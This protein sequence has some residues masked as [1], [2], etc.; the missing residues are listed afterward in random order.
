MTQRRF[1]SVYHCSTL[2]LYLQPCH[3]L[4]LALEPSLFRL[5]FDY[6]DLRSLARLECCCTTLQSM[7]VDTNIYRKKWVDVCERTGQSEGRGA[8]A[9]V[10]TSRYYK[11]KLSEYY[12]RSGGIF[13]GK[14]THWG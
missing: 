11:R 4:T 9:S 7:V 14:H 10:E 6:L 5:V 8:Q 3:L 2:S 13:A 1:V 12:L